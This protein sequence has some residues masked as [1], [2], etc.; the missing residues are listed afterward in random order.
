MPRRAS[1]PQPPSSR[2]P[3]S[4]PRWSVRRYGRKERSPAGMAATCRRWCPA[5]CRPGD[6]V[7]V[8][9]DTS[10]AAL[11][12]QPLPGGYQRAAAAFSA[13]VDHLDAQ[14]SRSKCVSEPQATAYARQALRAYGFTGWRVTGYR[15]GPGT[16]CAMF[17]ADSE[18]HT[19]LVT[20]VPG[21]GV[22]AVQVP[23]LRPRSRCTAWPPAGEYP[24]RAEEVPRG[25]PGRGIRA[26][27]GRGRQPGQQGAALLRRRQLRPRPP[28]DLAGQH[29]EPDP[30]TGGRPPGW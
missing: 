7:G 5:S 23:G 10:C 27:E 22:E 12:L 13:L 8:F 29:R 20:S 2:P 21:Q 19:I 11:R 14:L 25:A 9:P 26:V 1:P 3:A 18:R 28:D 4:P 16:R 30:V 15:P 17:A 24:G 6:A